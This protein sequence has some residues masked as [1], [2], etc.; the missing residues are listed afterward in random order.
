VNRVGQSDDVLR[1]AI[2]D[3]VQ[4][5]ET[6]DSPE[7]ADLTEALVEELT[8]DRRSPELVRTLWARLREVAPPVAAL[9]T[10]GTAIAHVLG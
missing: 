4:A 9:T 5:V 2:H 6:I 3:L 7:A 10:V 1:D 8:G